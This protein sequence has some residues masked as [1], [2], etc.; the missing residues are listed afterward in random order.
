MS[1]TSVAGHTMIDLF[2]PAS[3]DGFPLPARVVPAAA[4][5]GS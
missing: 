4:V 1:V 5:T 3:P 2:A